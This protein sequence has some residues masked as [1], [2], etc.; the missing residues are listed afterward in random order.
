[1]SAGT[2]DVSFF[3]PA[4]KNYRFLFLIF[5]CFMTFGSYWCYDIPDAIQTDLKK[6]YNLSSAHYALLYSVYNF[7]NIGIVLFGGYFIDVIGLRLGSI[8]FCFLI[9]LG[10]V[11]FSLGSNIHDT[12]TA[13]Y[14]M[15]AGRIIFSLGG[16]SLSVAQS[17]FT[18]KWFKGNELAFAFGIT[19]S[20]SRVG[21]FANLNITPLLAKKGLSYAI[22]A[23]SLT[24]LIS[25]AL[26]FFAAY[27]DRVRDRHL[28]AATAAAEANGAEPEKPKIPFRI[29]D[30]LH[31]PFSLW[32]IY[33]ICVFYYVP[34]FTTISISGLP[35]VESIFGF[36]DKTGNRYLSIPYIMSAVLAPIC[37]FIVDRAGRKPMF[38][39]MASALMVGTFAFLIFGV[40]YVHEIYM[41]IIAVVIL[42]VSYSFCAASLWPGVPLLVPEERVG[43]AYA[44]MNSIQNGGLAIAGVIA[45]VLGC[46]QKEGNATSCARKPIYF[47]AGVA[48]AALALSVVLTFWDMGHGGILSKKSDKVNETP[49]D[50]KAPLIS[51]KESINP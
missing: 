5:L 16:E 8:L 44:I 34:I 13:F 38:L 33:F 7:M 25:L 43:T 1:M 45:G 39:S 46:T 37:G 31:F 36:N 35:Y 48:V 50:E 2:G 28:N 32:L 21:S 26:T 30:I 11:V 17:T 15:L 20:F 47:L 14:V 40:Q 27:S 42:G 51:K 23:G 24:C 10:Q 22:W 49:E 29:S 12:N 3:H 19:L 4:H 6:Q 9:T 18:S 41:L